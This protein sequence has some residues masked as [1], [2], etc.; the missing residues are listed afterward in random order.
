MLVFFFDCHTP[1]SLLRSPLNRPAPFPLPSRRGKGWPVRPPSSSFLLLFRFSPAPRFT[2][3]ASVRWLLVDTLPMDNPGAT[4][5]SSERTSSRHHAGP[6]LRNNYATSKKYRY[7]TLISINDQL[8]YI[9]CLSLLKD[10]NPRKRPI[11][12]HIR[13]IS[14]KFKLQ[15]SSHYL[16]THSYFSGF[17]EKKRILRE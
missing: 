2:R 10:K 16:S 5:G 1:I 17:L 14:P 7:N 8:N 11:D 13:T 15:K 6:A 12:I 4:C 3:L 9:T